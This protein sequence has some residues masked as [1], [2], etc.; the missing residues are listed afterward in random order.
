MENSF[1]IDS[2]KNI[3]P[4]FKSLNKNLSCD[5]CI[6]GV[7][8]TGVS[9]A[10]KLSQKG[11]KDIVL[12]RN[13]IGS[14]T[15]GHTTGKLSSQHDIFYKYLLDSNGKDFANKYLKANENA[16]SDIKN[17]IDSENI[18]CDFEFQ[19]SYVFSEKEKEKVILKEEASIVNSLGFSANYLENLE[20][21]LNVKACVKF[22]NQAQFHPLKYIYGLA[23]CI[24]EKNGE[25][26]E[27]TTVYDIEKKDNHYITSTNDYTV[28]SKYI[29]IA[30]RYPFI[31][32]SGY[33]F[34]KMYQSISYAIACKVNGRN[35]SGMYINTKE[36][37]ISF[38]Y[39][40]DKDKNILIVTGNG[41]KV[42]KN[43][44]QENPFKLL[45]NIALKLH[46]E[47]Q[48]L[49]KWCTEDCISLDKI[50]YIGNLSDSMPNAFVATGFKKWGLTTSNIASNLISDLILKKEN[51]YKE[52]FL[53][54][55]FEPI[56]NREELTN[57]IKESVSSLV[58]D[59]FK[60]PEENLKDISNGE[61]KIIDYSSNKIGV[62]KDENGKIY[63]IKPICTHLGC[64]LEFNN[65]EKTWDCPCHGSRFSYDGTSIYSPAM[66][67]LS[68]YEL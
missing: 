30:S 27:N 24:I 59:K 36:P 4:S 39:T 28:S 52:I 61:G 11:L 45:E 43:K 22:P 65:I 18:D 58:I 14:K 6:I 49:N 7:G 12:E 10:Y 41:H 42:G 57:M 23:N 62:Y 21:P 19:D 67:N 1:W 35:F 46:P 16:I 3:A 9:T 53:S 5:I 50:P 63:A 56:K 17:I 38:R 2:T 68:R 48:I 37:I 29:V 20:L 33:Y 15:S 47:S 54:K 8:I 32:L 60:I 55:R 34:L 64:L 31:K 26:Y 40:T 51:P 13:F 44:I 25:I 66:K